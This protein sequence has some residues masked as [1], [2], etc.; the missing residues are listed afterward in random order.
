MRRVSYARD[1]ELFHNKSALDRR[2]VYMPKEMPRLKNRSI[3]C[4]ATVVR[5]VFIFCSACGL[6]S[7]EDGAENCSYAIAVASTVAAV[8]IV[9]VLAIAFVIAAHETFAESLS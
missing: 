7:A 5:P 8:S 6:G 9:R 2:G 3:S 4:S 1:N